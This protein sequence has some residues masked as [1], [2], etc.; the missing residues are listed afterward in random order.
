MK[1]F[2]HTLKLLKRKAVEE[3]QLFVLDSIIRKLK[4]HCLILSDESS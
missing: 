3:D 2:S 4:F 1:S